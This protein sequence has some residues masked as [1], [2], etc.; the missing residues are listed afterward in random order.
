[1]LAIAWRWND[2]FPLDSKSLGRRLSA[3]LCSGIGGH[4]GFA[5][6]DGIHFAYRP[7]QSSSVTARSWRPA[8]L[9]DGR[10]VVFHGYFDNAAEVAAALGAGTDDVSRLYGLAVERWGDDADL[11]IIGEYCA[12]IAEPRAKQLRLSR[13]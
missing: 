10:I 1:M 5:E 2:P 11:K 9:A 7:R 13:S 12:V 6:L 4:A 3:S 8:Q